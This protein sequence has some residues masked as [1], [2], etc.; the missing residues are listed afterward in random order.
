MWGI[1]KEGTEF[2]IA[3]IE[4]LTYDYVNWKLEKRNVL[5][6][7]QTALTSQEM[8]NWCILDNYPEGKS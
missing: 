6:G 1:R 4:Q 5:K 2:E 3:K 7:K 8:C